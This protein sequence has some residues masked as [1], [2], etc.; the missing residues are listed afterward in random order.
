MCVCLVLCVHAWVCGYLCVCV[1]MCI[2]MLRSMYFVH[3]CLCHW[4][5]CVFLLVS[6]WFYIGVCLYMFMYSL[7]VWMGW[8]WKWKENEVMSPSL[9]AHVFHW[10]FIPLA[11]LIFLLAYLGEACSLSNM[12]FILSLPLH[13]FKFQ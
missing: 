2:W 10:T 7:C 1:C 13:L 4:S 6:I 5:L 12:Y 3:L 8:G 9:Q 11:C